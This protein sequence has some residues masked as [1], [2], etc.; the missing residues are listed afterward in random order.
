MGKMS[1]ST[2]AYLGQSSLLLVHV[3]NFRAVQ[4]RV[5]S[6]QYNIIRGYFS[7]QPTTERLG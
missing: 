7:A 5:E 2:G 1:K 4:R 3:L 6:I